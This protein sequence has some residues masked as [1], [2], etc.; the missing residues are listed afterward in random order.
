MLASIADENVTSLLRVPEQRYWRF[1]RGVQS[2]ALAQVLRNQT[3][4]VMSGSGTCALA[5][6]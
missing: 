5:S 2:K 4:V 1:D 3:G 6:R